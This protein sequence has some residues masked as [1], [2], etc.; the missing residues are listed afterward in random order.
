MATKILTD[1]DMRGLLLAVGA[2]PTTN[3]AHYARSFDELDLDSLA[4]VEI[5]SRIRDRF[6]VNIE[7]EMVAEQT[8]AAMRDLVNQRLTSVSS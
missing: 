1:E 8:P 4:R 6:G 2:D 5:A 3:S 7:E